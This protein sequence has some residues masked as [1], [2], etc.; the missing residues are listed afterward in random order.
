MS[1]NNVCKQHAFKSDGVKDRK[2]GRHNHVQR[3]YR[4]NQQALYRHFVQ[5]FGSN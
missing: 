4:D 3:L 1:F 5:L 2:K